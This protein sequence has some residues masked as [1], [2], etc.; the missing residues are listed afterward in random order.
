[1]D[2]LPPYAELD[3]ILQGLVEEEATLDEIVAR[4]HAAETVAR[5]Q[6]LLYASEYKR[7]QAQPGVKIGGKA[8]GRDRRYPLVNAFRDRIGGFGKG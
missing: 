3:G 7:R 5:I 2:S 8:F 1:Q 6:Q 4:G